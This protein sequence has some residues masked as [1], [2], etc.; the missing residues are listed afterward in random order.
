MKTQ[1]LLIGAA[2]IILVL[3]SIGYAFYASQN[4]AAA[5]KPQIIITNFAQCVEAGNPVMES[6]PREC[7]AGDQTFTEEVA[8]PLPVVTPPTTPPPAPQAATTSTSA[9][10]MITVATPLPNAKI[11]SPLE[12]TGSARGNWYFEASFPVVLVDAKGKTIAQSPAQAKGEWMTTEF[13]PFSV[14]LTWSK[15]TATSGT[16]IL[17][18]D[19]PSGLPENDKEIRIPV[20][21]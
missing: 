21:F 19:N 3:G 8:P 12:I 2:I 16:L 20:S 1:T 17:K 14:T 10:S 18:R 4:S 6:Y 15:N 7:K 13:V 11:K 9:E 5:I